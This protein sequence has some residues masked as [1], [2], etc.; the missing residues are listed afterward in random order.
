MN[1]ENNTMPKNECRTYH[2]LL[3]RWANSKSDT[4]KHYHKYQ[5]HLATCPKCAQWLRAMAAYTN[6]PL[7]PEYAEWV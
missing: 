3:S 7:A 4:M 5:Q 6:Q 1:G 2:R